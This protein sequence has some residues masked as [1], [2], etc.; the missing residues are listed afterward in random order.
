MRLR[1]PFPDRR[2]ESLRNLSGTAITIREL[3][4]GFTTA[5]FRPTIRTKSLTSSL[6][7]FLV[8][9]QEL[10]RD[11]FPRIRQTAAPGSESL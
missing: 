5:Q 10:S 3:A 4:S 9:E 6:Y 11:V 8:R 7:R 1:L 2:E